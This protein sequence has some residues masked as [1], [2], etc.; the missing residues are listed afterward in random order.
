MGNVISDR[1]GLRPV[2]RVGAEYVVKFS[3]NPE[4][5]QEAENIL[6]LNQHSQVRTPKVY[7]AFSQQGGNPLNHPMCEDIVYHYLV[8]EYIEG[9]HLDHDKYVALDPEDKDKICAKIA[10]QLQL[11]RSIP[12][13]SPGYYGRV[14]HQ[15]W[16]PGF[17]VVCVT[18]KDMCGPYDT[19]ED[20]IS[21]M[22][23]AATGCAAVCE[24]TSP[25]FTP[26]QRLGLTNFK[27]TLT[28]CAGHEPT[29]THLDLKLEN[30]MVRPVQGVN[31]IDYEV[32]LIDWE[33]LGWMPAWMEAVTVLQRSVFATKL[34][35]W[36]FLW[37]VSQGIK[38]FHMG[39]AT[40]FNELEDTG[41]LHL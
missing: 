14:M 30:I 28:E 9:G 20:F 8:M 35:K 27:H 40:F 5:L 38:P 41:I 23:T 36:R 16:M 32:T 2:F 25:D 26:V 15:G 6:F 17:P 12:P 19:Y 7:A 4:I 13:P 22:F 24:P 11:L 34:D 31:G 10:E 1:N 37:G 3:P 18:R 21:A 29:L 39:P 33:S